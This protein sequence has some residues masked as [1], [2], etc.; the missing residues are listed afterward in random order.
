MLARIKPGE[1]GGAGATDVQ[2]TGGTGGKSGLYGHSLYNLF[3]G[4]S[5]SYGSIMPT[6]SF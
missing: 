3:Q 2:V 5:V 6:I 4:Y 1:Q